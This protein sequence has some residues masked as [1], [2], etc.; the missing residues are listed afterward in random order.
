ME[1]EIAELRAKNAQ[2]L[3]ANLGATVLR[4]ELAESRAAHAQLEA[5]L[6]APLAQTRVLSWADA[7]PEPQPSIE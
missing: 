3:R 2:L 4:S 6:N 7:E 1:T 5:S